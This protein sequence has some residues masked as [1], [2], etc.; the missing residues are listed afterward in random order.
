MV[1]QIL[2]QQVEQPLAD[3]LLAAEARP[4]VVT[5]EVK[6]KKIVLKKG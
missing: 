6:D 5:V 1:T 3:V 4:R 2:Q